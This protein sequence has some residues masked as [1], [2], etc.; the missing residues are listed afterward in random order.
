MTAPT[1]SQSTLSHARPASRLRH[2]VPC[3]LAT[4]AT[5]V[6]A[7]AITRIAAQKPRSRSR[8][9]ESP[10]QAFQRQHSRLE[11]IEHSPSLHRRHRA[12]SRKL[13]GTPRTSALRRTSPRSG[14]FGTRRSPS[15]ASGSHAAPR[16]PPSTGKRCIGCSIPTRSRRRAAHRPPVRHVA[17]LTFEEPGCV[18][19]HVRICGRPGGQPPGLPDHAA[20]GRG[21]RQETWSS[22]QRPCRRVRR[23]RS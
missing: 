18:N 5:G 11:T 12:L 7:L 9:P 20:P 15:G 1:L 2:T 3:A 22:W 6:V 17:N 13:T 23:A 21:R 8:P 10:A 4:I 19:A 14:G 16:R